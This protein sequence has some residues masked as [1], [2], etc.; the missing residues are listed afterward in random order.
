[1]SVRQL[2]DSSFEWLMNRA[3]WLVGDKQES[4]KVGGRHERGERG[5]R[6]EG[7]QAWPLDK[8]SREKLPLDWSHP[9]ISCLPVKPFVILVLSLCRLEMDFLALGRIHAVAWFRSQS[10][11]QIYFYDNGFV[12]TK[13]WPGNRLVTVPGDVQERAIAGGR[14]GKEAAAKKFPKRN[15]GRWI[16][17]LTQS[18]GRRRNRWKSGRCCCY[19]EP[20]AWNPGHVPPFE[21]RLVESAFSAALVGTKNKEL[22]CPTVPASS[23]SA[24]LAEWFKM[25]HNDI[26]TLVSRTHWLYLFLDA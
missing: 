6:G 12:W 21:C 10:R 2:C 16:W 19:N 22:I 18:R 17:C 15:V 24:I 8:G 4:C 25:T 11:F 23:C 26:M 9:T 20:T 1:M 3:W 5:E 13:V 7:N 14:S